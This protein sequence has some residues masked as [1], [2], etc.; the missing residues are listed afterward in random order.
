IFVLT[1]NLYIGLVGTVALVGGFQIWA[2]A[3]VQL[4]RIGLHPAPDAAGVHFDAA[5]RQKFSDM[6]VSQGIPQVP[7]DTEKN[8]RT[9]KM[10]PFERIGRGDRHGLLP[11]QT[12][13]PIFAMEPLLRAIPGS[14]E[15]RPELPSCPASQPRQR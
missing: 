9:R 8:H 3:L 6:F 13:S 7:A 11:Y 2:A 12:P 4:R 1:L 5:F 10:A 14:S 15:L